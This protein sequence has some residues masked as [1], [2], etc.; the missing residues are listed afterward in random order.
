MAGIDASEELIE[1]ATERVP[2]GDFRVSDIEALPWE[3]DSV[4]VLR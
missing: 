1:I 2:E 4:D 3:N